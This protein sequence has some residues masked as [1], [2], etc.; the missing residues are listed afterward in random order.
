MQPS[1]GLSSVSAY[2][3]GIPSYLIHN[4]IA[5][6]FHGTEAGDAL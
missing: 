3:G 5:V 2:K 1:F 4:N 6:V